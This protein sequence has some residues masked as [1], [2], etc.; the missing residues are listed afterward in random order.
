[1]LAVDVEIGCSIYGERELVGT[2]L[3]RGQGSFE[4]CVEEV[5]GYRGEFVVPR[6]QSESEMLNVA[7][8]FLDL[9][10]GGSV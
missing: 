9:V 3:G 7:R 5:C 6:K 8:G 4:F 10:E 2:I 1:L